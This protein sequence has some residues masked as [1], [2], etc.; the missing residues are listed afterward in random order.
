MSKARWSIIIAVCAVSKE[1]PEP[2]CQPMLTGSMP[3]STRFQFS[4]STRAV[5][6]V[7][8]VLVGLPKTH[9]VPPALS[10]SPLYR[11]RI[12]ARQAGRAMCAGGTPS[13][14]EI[15]VCCSLWIFTAV[16]LIIGN[17]LLECS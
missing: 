12:R 8:T 5:Q 11:D 1:L 16:F 17:A 10:H 9:V 2:A 3:L 13:S 7:H 4:L 6:L 14:P 15:W